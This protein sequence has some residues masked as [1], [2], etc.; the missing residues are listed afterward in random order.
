MTP[1]E[2]FATM[3]QRSGVSMYHEKGFKG[4]GINILNC[5]SF[6]TRHG[7]ATGTIIK[8]IAPDA[9]FFCGSTGIQV[10]GDEL[11]SAQIELDDGTR[12]DLYEFVKANKIDIMSASKSGITDTCKGWNDYCKKMQDDTGVII[13][14][15]AGNEF[16]GNGETLTS[17]FPPN[18]AILVGAI[19]INNV[20][21]SYSSV[22]EELDF[23]AYSGLI[24][25]TSAATPFL[26]GMMACI[27]SR[28]R[29]LT[30][31]E[32]YEY[33]KRI[34]KDLGTTG[35]DIYY[36]EGM[37]ILPE[38]T[39]IQLQIGSDKMIVDGIDFKIDQPPKIDPMTGRTLVPVRA[40]AEGFG[41][42]VT[43]I[44]ETDTI[45]LEV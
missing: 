3:M 36:G 37:P 22:G 44:D 13:F 20:R 5:E 6:L 45:I 14:N 35:D 33:L 41:A 1:Q 21:A 27:M 2:E 18:V 32:A 7:E 31:P 42:T 28:Y 12:C 29:K 43:W 4:K 24:G 15:A 34:S 17:H 9:N 11:M 40:I 8:R 10:K 26:A 30:P 38:K 16:V 23:M 19:T 25:G 39:R